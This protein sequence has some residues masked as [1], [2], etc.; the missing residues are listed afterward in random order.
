MRSRWIL[1]L[2]VCVT[3]LAAGG[4]W[5][6]QQRQAGKLGAAAHALTAEMLA[7]G[8]RPPGSA[9]LDAVRALVTKRM[10]QAGWSVRPQ[11]FQRDTPVG[12]IRFVNLRARFARAGADPWQSVPEGLLCAHIDSK[13][14]RDQTFLGADDAASACAALVELAG[15]LARQRPEQASRLELVWF[16]G[17]EAFGETI[18]PQ[19]GLYGSRHYAGVWRGK[20]RKPAF[21]ILLDMI[22]HQGLNIRIPSDSPPELAAALFTAAEREGVRGAFGTA[23]GP[24]IDDHIPLNSAGIPTLDVIGDFTRFRWW[25]TPADQ[26]KIVS[27]ESLDVSMRVVLQMLDMRW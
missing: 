14:M 22:G 4:W 21:G 18:T 23:A 26:L 16:D 1:F 27:P 15:F 13:L 11:E 20:D 7:I 19:D 24:I 6:W 3:A 25:H 5:W 10:E 12:N 17:E 8:P 2:T 9:G